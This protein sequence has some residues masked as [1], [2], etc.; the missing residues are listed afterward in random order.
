M[1]DGDPLVVTW[2][3][4]QEEL[5]LEVHRL[6]RT[7]RAIDPPARCSV[8]ELTEPG[9]DV[10]CGARV[11]SLRRPNHQTLDLSRGQ[12]RAL[13]WSSRSRSTFAGLLQGDVRS[14]G[15]GRGSACRASRKRGRAQGSG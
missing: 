2:Q 10:R 3:V 1:I 11:T 4:I 14:R 6:V 9:P 8:S 7:K 13:G 15:A 5:P 12:W